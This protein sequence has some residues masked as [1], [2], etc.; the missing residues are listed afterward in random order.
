MG[1]NPQRLDRI[2]I[3]MELLNKEGAK[4]SSVNKLLVSIGMSR[5]AA[6]AYATGKRSMGM[7]TL[8]KLA[9]K[10]NINPAYILY[11]HTPVLLS[12]E[13]TLEPQKE[14]DTS[15]GISFDRLLY[16][17]QQERISDL[18]RFISRLEK[19]LDDKDKII[20]ILE[21]AHRKS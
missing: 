19:S 5:Q 20:R 21:G 17:E 1:N 18:R 8:S 16:K 10:Y 15:I 3:A 11:G 12:E 7:E 13:Q 6:S 9:E 14:Y 4:I 2:K